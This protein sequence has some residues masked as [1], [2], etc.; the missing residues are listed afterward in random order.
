MTLASL[1]LTAEQKPKM[2]KL[3]AECGKGGCTKESMAK[4]NKEAEQVLTK[5]QFVT[6]KAA[7]EGEKKSDKTQS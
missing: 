7:C 6:W 4:M 2:E 3:A 5:E 1:N